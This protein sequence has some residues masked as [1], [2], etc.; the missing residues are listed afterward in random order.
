MGIQSFSSLVVCYDIY[1][2]QNDNFMCQPQSKSDIKVAFLLQFLHY[3]HMILKWSLMTCKAQSFVL[4]LVHWSHINFCQ[5][6]QCIYCQQRAT[7]GKIMIFHLLNSIYTNTLQL[8]WIF[9]L[10]F[11]SLT[12]HW[13]NSIH[14]VCQNEKIFFSNALQIYFLSLHLNSNIWI[15]TLFFLLPQ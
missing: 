11:L 8:R 12:R 3:Y 15:W 2:S 14:S 9:F 6:T 7:V 4:S 13:A 1:G 5:K 10:F